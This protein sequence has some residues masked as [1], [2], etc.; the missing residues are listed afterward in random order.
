MSLRRIAADML[1]PSR[2]LADVDH[3]AEIRELRGTAA[4]AVADL[5][6]A[7]ATHVAEVAIFEAMLASAELDARN[8]R[9]DV[10]RLLEDAH[11][12]AEQ[13]SKN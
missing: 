7:R 10:A 2:L 3:Q 11:R 8:A 9:A 5:L 13:H 1:D 6:R 4:K 12:C